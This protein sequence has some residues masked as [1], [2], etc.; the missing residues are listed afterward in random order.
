YRD[1]K[2][3]IKELINIIDIK[4]QHIKSRNK[5][6]SKHIKELHR[7]IKEYNRNMKKGHDESIIE[8][9]V[10][11]IKTQLTIIV[12]ELNEQEQSYKLG[13]N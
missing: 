2:N 10:R 9:Q 8:D 7:M 13:G 3:N 6:I 5:N 4:A 11:E 1:N 12:E